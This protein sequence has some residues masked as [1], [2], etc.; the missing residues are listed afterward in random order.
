G[1][2]ADS[3]ATQGPMSFPQGHPLYGPGASTT[4]DYTL[5]LEA[6]AAT[7]ALMG[8]TNSTLLNRDVTHIGFGGIAP[9]VGGN[10]GTGRGN[11][12]GGRTIDVD[13]EASLPVVIEEVRKQISPD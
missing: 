12:P 11:S 9:G 1:A 5:G 10:P 6:P 3:A 13:A 4:Y 7:V 8:P 2:S